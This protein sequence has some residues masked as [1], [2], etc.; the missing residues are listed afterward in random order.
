MPRAASIRRNPSTAPSPV[1]PLLLL[2][3]AGPLAA[4]KPT[5]EQFFSAASPLELVP[6]RNADRVAWTAYER[7]MR[8]VYTAA[9]PDFRPVRLTAFLEDDGTD[10]SGVTLS[11]DGSTIVF[12]RGSAPNRQGWVAN[13]SHDPDG[14]ERALWAV[15]TSGGKAWRLGPGSTPALAPDGSAVVFVRDGQ[16][17]RFRIG[18]GGTDPAMDTAGIP[19]IR[20]WGEQSSPRWSPDGSKIA[21]VSQRVNHSFIGVY[22]VAKRTVNFVAPD[23]DCDANPAWSPDGRRIA[24]VRRPGAPFGLQAQAGS[25]GI[26]NPSGAAQGRGGAA[27]SPFGGCGG[28]FGGRGG[29]GG[30]R[31]D[32][33][34]PPPEGLRA[35][36]GLY[37]GLLPGGATVAVMV[38][39]VA[40][41]TARAVWANRPDEG[42]FTSVGA[43][44]WAGESLIFPFTPQDDD[45]DRWWKLAVD[46]SDA[47]PVL[48]TTTDG[49]IEG[50]VSAAL[51]TDGRTLYYATNAGDIERRHIWAVPTS[52]GTPRQVSRGAIETNP[53][54]LPSGRLAL[55]HFDAKQP[56]SVGIV[57]QGGGATRLVFPD[58]P[59]DFPAAAHVVPEIVK[60]KAADGLEISNQ[61]FLPAG[62]R[63]GE[64]R[65]AMVFVHG[66]PVRQMLPGYHYMQFYHWAY[67]FN[68][69]LAS[70]GYIVLSI[71][72][73][74]GIGYGHAFRQA[75]NTNARGNSEYQDVLAGAAY[76]QSRADVDP[77]RIGIWG[78]SYGGLLTAQ[79]LARNSDIFVAGVDLAGVHLY[80]SAIDTAAVSWRSSSVSEIGN[81]KSPV[82]LVHGDDDRNVDFSQTIGLVQLL[83][84]HG[85]H[86]ELMVVPDDLHESMFHGI[87]MDTWNRIGDFLGRFVRDRQAA[88][89]DSRK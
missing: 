53:A 58:L 63:P 40:T 17:Y 66:G 64:K 11:A 68:Q 50:A 24:F 34:P 21:F 7:G 89:P 73:R 72:F 14:A 62:L 88:A 18:P 79:A 22:D 5:I 57:P 69:W 32:A 67:G 8:N 84:G 47:R 42:V 45:W 74:G 55:L 54:P 71:N 70:Q 33:P 12:V 39:D 60:T 52:G 61:L 65:P 83:R 1:L 59:A 43:L 15:R 13:P 19:F 81:W 56:A 31:G 46:G 82:F 10:V 27:A 16:I 41:G 6:A 51:S 44:E 28:G 48:L 37:R 3:L 75:A 78:L 77:A 4:Q 80:G 29:G 9:A 2:G 85:V 87:W 86:Y 36:P 25:G 20:A 35:V 26:G 38:A 30:G 76:L 49:L 23:V